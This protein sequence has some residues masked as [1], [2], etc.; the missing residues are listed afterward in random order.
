MSD[1]MVEEIA[2][3]HETIKA[4]ETE[5]KQYAEANKTLAELVKGKKWS[6][7]YEWFFR[8]EWRWIP[9]WRAFEWSG[10]KILFHRK[11]FG[12]FEIRRYKVDELVNSE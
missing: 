5:N 12:P 11:Y 3:L 6:I 10:Y 1:D 8:K 7:R 9:H 4:L 2:G